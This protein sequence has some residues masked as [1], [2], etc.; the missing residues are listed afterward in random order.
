MLACVALKINWREEPGS[1]YRVVEGQEQECDHHE[2]DESHAPLSQHLEGT[3][4]ELGTE[5]MELPICWNSRMTP[6]D[7][8]LQ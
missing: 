5:K 2:H 3:R 1:P 4:L 6:A 8:D 7:A